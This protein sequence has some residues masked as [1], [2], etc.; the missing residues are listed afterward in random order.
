MP[1]TLPLRVWSVEAAGGWT[2][3]D[4]EQMRLWRREMRPIYC[5]NSLRY[6]A[7]RYNSLRYNRIVR[8]PALRVCRVTARS[9]RHTVIHTLHPRSF[10]KSRGCSSGVGVVKDPAVGCRFVQIIRRRR[11]AG[12]LVH[13]RRNLALSAPQVLDQGVR[14]V[15]KVSR[16]DLNDNFRATSAAVKVR[17]AHE[18][19]GRRR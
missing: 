2:C 17:V 12:A 15:K 14:A 3:R 13:G 6:N 10:P 18:E 11:V 19:A 8:C 16:I 9:L 7:L 4:R 1:R 5:N